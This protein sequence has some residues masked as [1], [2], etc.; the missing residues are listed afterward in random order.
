VFV[1][2]YPEFVGLYFD[3]FP[4]S[5]SLSLLGLSTNPERMKLKLSFPL[6]GSSFRGGRG[7]GAVIA[8]V[9]ATTLS[10]TMIEHQSPLLSFK[11]PLLLLED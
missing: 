6:I 7:G 8:I 5:L 4:G 2:L 9:V 3:G 11:E 10:F 1:G